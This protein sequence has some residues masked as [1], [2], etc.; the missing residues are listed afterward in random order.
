MRS[1]EDSLIKGAGRMLAVAVVYYVAA[2][3]S[4]RL[5]LVGESV[6]PLWPPTGIALVAFIWFGPRVWPA[7]AAAAFAVN[8]PI[9]SGPAVAAGIAAG[10]TLAPLVSRRLLVAFN[11]DERLGRLRDVLTLVFM[12]ALAAMT[13]STT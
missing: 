12:G 13:V 1:A 5:A 7:I 11:F 2:R 10:N 3:L 4:L 9:S 6:T 8:L